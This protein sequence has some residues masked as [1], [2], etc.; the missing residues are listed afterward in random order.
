MRHILNVAQACLAKD[1]V[2]H[3]SDPGAHPYT[4]RSCIRPEGHPIAPAPGAVAPSNGAILFR[5]SAVACPEDPTLEP[6]TTLLAVPSSARLAAGGGAVVRGLCGLAF[7]WRRTL[8][9]RPW[10]P[11]R[12]PMSLPR[13]AERVDPPLLQS[14][15]PSIPSIALIQSCI[16]SIRACY[17]GACSSPRTAPS[18]IWQSKS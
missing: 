10:N 5:N 17:G 6:R 15:P 7:V 12:A 11:T 14:K 16:Q 18:A 9:I 13:F 4:G 8:W 3:G 1:E 2:A